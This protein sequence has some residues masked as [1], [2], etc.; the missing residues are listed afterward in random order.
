MRWLGERERKK[1]KTDI[2]SWVEI[3][4]FTQYFVLDASRCWLWMIPD[5][6]KTKA[7]FD[8]SC[9]ETKPALHCNPTRS[10]VTSEHNSFQINQ[11][12]LEQNEA[13]WTDLNKMFYGVAD[14]LIRW[15]EWYWYTPNVSSDRLI[16]INYVKNFTFCEKRCAT[17]ICLS[18]PWLMCSI[19]Q[20]IHCMETCQHLQNSS[21]LSII[22]H[23]KAQWW[24][25]VHFVAPL[26]ILATGAS[27]VK[28]VSYFGIAVYQ[29][30]HYYILS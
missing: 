27:I 30:V 8:Y 26:I 19:L 6:M 3:T 23:F 5:A 28:S 1:N 24:K 17:P 11:L 21:A 15:K 16:L 18:S 29:N 12:T 9:R 20:T 22:K 2:A 25:P 13:T 10:E 7:Y 14:W 4:A